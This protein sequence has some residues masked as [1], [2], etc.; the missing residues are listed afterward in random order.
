MLLLLVVPVF[1]GHGQTNTPVNPDAIN[2]PQ[3]ARDIRRG[4]IVAF[5]SFP[6][7]M[8]TASFLM[9]M[10]RWRVA[11]G[12]D[13]SDE[14][15]RYAPWPLKSTGGQTGTYGM[16]SEETGQVIAIA[17]GIAVAVAITDHVIIQIKRN[18]ERRRAEAIPAGTVTINQSPWGTHDEPPDV[19]DDNDPDDVDP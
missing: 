13:F 17:A 3:W 9:D 19:Q 4:E 11:N 12:L 10:H 15:R 1:L 18:R 16:T 5:G 7:A 2:F 8:F 6:F 14:G